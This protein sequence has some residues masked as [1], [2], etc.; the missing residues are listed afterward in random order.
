MEIRPD[1]EPEE[2][3]GGELGIRPPIESPERGPD[4]G[5]AAPETSLP[6]FQSFR[7]HRLLAV[8]LLG[9]AGLA[10]LGGGGYIALGLWTDL[11]VSDAAWSVMVELFFCLLQVWELWLAALMLR[12][13]GLPLKAFLARAPELRLDRF[14]GLNL[15]LVIASFGLAMPASLFLLLTGDQ[16]GSGLPELWADGDGLALTYNL[17]NLLS[18]VLLAPVVEELVFRGIFLHR[19]TVKWNLRD[20]ILI[21]SLIFGLLHGLNLG[22]FVFGLVMSLLY[23]ESGSLRLTIA[24]HSL[25]NALIMLLGWLIATGSIHYSP[26]VQLQIEVLCLALSGCGLLYWFWKREEAWTRLPPFLVAVTPASGIPR[27][28][29]PR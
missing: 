25:H 22:A 20:A 23:L 19:L 28:T 1:T 9:A 2:A 29:E 5:P 4:A 6:P 3:A 18:A 10:L 17:L 7:I 8:Y 24:C 21:S 13:R 14:A 11:E 15:M 16:P 12:R 26:D 27:E